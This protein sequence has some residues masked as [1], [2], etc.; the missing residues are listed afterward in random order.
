MTPIYIWKL[1]LKIYS[2]NIGMQKIDSYTFKTF[3]IVL[4]SFQVNNKLEKAW[5][6]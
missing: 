5:F 6:L 1:G 3:E 4:T 2:I